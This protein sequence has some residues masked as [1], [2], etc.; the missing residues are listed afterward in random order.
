[1]NC[2]EGPQRYIA[3][4]P[5]ERAG[6]RS[7]RVNRL[8]LST[9][10][11]VARRGSSFVVLLSLLVGAQ[12]SATNAPEDFEF[13]ESEVR[14]ILVN[15]CYGCHSNIARS[16]RSDF[17]LD[18][19]ASLLKGGTR[20]P[21]VVPGK[22]EESLLIEAIRRESLEMPPSGPNER[23][24]GAQ[25][26]VL[27]KWV[28]MGAPWPEVSESA[29][30]S[31]EGRYDWETAR[32][33]WAWQP[34]QKVSPPPVR[35]KKKVRNPIDQFVV[36]GLRKAGLKQ[37]KPALAAVF[38]RRA[39]FDLIGMPPTPDEL[40]HW[41]VA[42]DATRKGNLNDDAVA[43]L[44]DALLERPQYGERW[45]RLWLDLVRYS[46]TGGWSQDNGSF[47]NAWRY[48]DW[49]VDALNSDM[50]Y[51]EFVRHQIAGDTID[52]EASIGTGFFAL[53][54]SYSS[55]GGDPVA[56][57]Q[58][59]SE[60]LDDRVDTFSRTFLG[61][62]MACARCHDHKFDPIPIQDYYSIAGI[63]NNS[64]GGETPLVG[65]EVVR[66]Y[67][68]VRRPINELRVKVRDVRQTA[69][70][71]KRPVSDE[72][73][74]QIEAWQ[75]ESDKLDEE[76]PPKY[77]FVH[78]LSDT[79]GEDMRVAVRGNL[80]KPGQVAPRRFLRLIEGKEREHF[81]EGS[82]RRQLADAVVDPGNPLT[83]RVIVNRIWM[84]HFG[85]ALVRTPSNFGTLGEKPTHPE[86]LDW[87][88]ST[89]ME[90]GWSIKSLHRTIM[91]SATYR[92]SSAFDERAFSADGDNRSIWRMN[93]RRMDVETWRDSLLAVTNELD[94]SLGGPPVENIVDSNRRTL[95]ASVSR[96]D[97]Y[98][99]DEFLRLF[100]FPIPRASSAKR[101]S[102]VIPQQFLFMMNSSFMLDRARALGQ[103]LQEESGT[104]EGQIRQGY[105]LLYG[106]QPSEREL[107]TAARFLAG[108]MPTESGPDRWQQYCQV[109]LS[110]NEFMYIR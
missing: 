21:A 17:R 19:R 24:N 62:T 38:V 66:E 68:E 57:A 67:Q 10:R 107:E 97:P 61:L 32:E 40:E 11:H 36:D 89:F 5:P 81:T 2:P 26:A 8:A 20:G 34:I 47:P 77:A 14:P 71:E 95:Y 96:N 16:V 6:W 102:S 76:S 46:D 92:S 33:H 7:G 50:P 80:M 105:H 18:S 78:T 73:Q 58:A 88:A 55:D 44:I 25:I 94:V 63:F 3:S 101:T 31:G 53:G 15:Y 98:I 42:L 41:V 99:T 83:A 51:N 85:R 69:G 13:F 1:M 108:D 39:F 79:G 65:A 23:L 109:L 35:K 52:R 60:T 74:M 84:N 9:L 70:K 110:A 49:V 75:A 93:A 22:P 82:G 54:P 91:M 104:Q 72:E 103:R 59:K 29:L 106:R 4:E 90:S 12:G 28:E 27:T 64:K 45:G 87:L 100:D 86:L 43:Q 56:T 30:R 37:P 48:R